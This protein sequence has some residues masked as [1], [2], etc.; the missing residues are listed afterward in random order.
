MTLENGN[1]RFYIQVS[2]L[3]V[4]PVL[5]TGR[6]SPIQVHPSS[7]LCLLSNLQISYPA[8]SNKHLAQIWGTKDIQAPR[9]WNTCEND[10]SAELHQ[11]ISFIKTKS[12]LHWAEN[13]CPHEPTHDCSQQFVI[14][15]ANGKQPNRPSIGARVN[16]LWYIHTMAW[17]SAIRK[18]SYPATK[19]HGGILSTDC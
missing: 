10:I 8:W 9:M 4:S 6:I 14:T 12:Q 2:D 11:Q 13:F 5:E 16:K 7:L 18:N 17:Y 19:R 15:A 3:C 1:V